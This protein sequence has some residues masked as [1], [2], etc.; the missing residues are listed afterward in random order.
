MSPARDALSFFV[1]AP[2]DAVVQLIWMGLLRTLDSG[3]MGGDQG[4]WP[5]L[6]AMLAVT[7]GG[8]F[9][10]SALIGILTTGIEGRIEALRKGR[11]K[12]V[13]NGHTVILGWSEQVFRN[14]AKLAMVILSAR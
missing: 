2:R 10:V 1:P 6:F 3:T 11:S 13:E 12:V 9:V 8:I 5:F 7:I 14:T 4:S